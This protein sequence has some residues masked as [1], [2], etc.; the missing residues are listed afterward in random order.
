MSSF[1]IRDAKDRHDGPW[2]RKKFNEGVVEGLRYARP[3]A[4]LTKRDEPLQVAE[5]TLASGERDEM[6]VLPRL[7]MLICTKAI[8]SW[9]VMS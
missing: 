1:V 4:R 9:T 2:T 5:R 3:Y 6:K 8:L 7:R